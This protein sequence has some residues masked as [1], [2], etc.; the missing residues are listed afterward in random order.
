MH[1]RAWLLHNEHLLKSI[2]HQLHAFIS[3]ILLMLLTGFTLY[4]SFI[5][6]TLSRDSGNNY[7]TTKHL[8]LNFTKL[9]VYSFSFG[10]KQMNFRRLINV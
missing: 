7:I 5:Q 10:N 3:K 4:N 1:N 8:S 2:S 6:E 9:S